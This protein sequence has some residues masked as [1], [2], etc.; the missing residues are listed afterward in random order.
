MGIDSP[1]GV[2]LTIWRPLS[3]TKALALHQ[4]AAGMPITL[5]GPDDIFQQEAIVWHVKEDIWGGVADFTLRSSL[6]D[7]LMNGFQPTLPPDQRSMA[8]FHAF[9]SQC[10]NALSEADWSDSVVSMENDGSSAIRI[11]ALIAFYAQ[12]S[13][14]YHVFKDLPGA[15]VSVQ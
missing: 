9:L 15:S 4:N 2:R 5:F 12:S 11:N 13:W 1:L 8:H 14:I 6:Q 10:D 7:G 3:P